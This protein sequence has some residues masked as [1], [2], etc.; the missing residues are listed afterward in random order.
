MLLGSSMGWRVGGDKEKKMKTKYYHN[1]Q[2]GVRK[3][4]KS[5]NSDKM[6]EKVLKITYYVL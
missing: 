6:K 5:K 1:L 2:T 3:C 4:I